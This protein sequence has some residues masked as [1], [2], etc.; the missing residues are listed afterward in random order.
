[1]PERKNSMKH[2]KKHRNSHRIASQFASHRIALGEISMGIPG[3]VYP[4]H[5]VRKS[6]T[7]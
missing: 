5:T 2:R 3:K 1:M 7:K 4:V 6:P